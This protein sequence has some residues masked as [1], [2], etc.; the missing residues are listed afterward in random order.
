MLSNID[1]RTKPQPQSPCSFMQ[2]SLN[3]ILLTR[4]SI[5][6]KITFPWSHLHKIV[7][8]FPTIIVVISHLKKCV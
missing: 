6:S 8:K 2:I 7:S 1:V 4:N 3:I 5:P